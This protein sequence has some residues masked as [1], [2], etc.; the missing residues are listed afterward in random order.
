MWV[1]VLVSFCQLYYFFQFAFIVVHLVSNSSKTCNHMWR[2]FRTH[3]STHTNIHLQNAIYFSNTQHYK[4]GH[5]C[6]KRRTHSH[7][8]NQEQHDMVLKPYRL[9]YTTFILNLYI[10]TIQPLSF[11]LRLSIFIYFHFIPTIWYF[12]SRFSRQTAVSQ[13]FL[14]LVVAVR[15]IQ[16]ISFKTKYGR[17]TS[18]IEI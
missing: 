13:Q 1:C 11:S 6:R 5:P 12:Y 3:F 9:E 4:W 14:F 2:H 8:K 17:M 10:R 15:T 18:K 16:T 7:W